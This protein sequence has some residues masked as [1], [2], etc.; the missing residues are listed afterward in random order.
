LAINL[1]IYLKYIDF[2]YKLENF[3]KNC[4]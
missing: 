4:R 2:N 3:V 1:L